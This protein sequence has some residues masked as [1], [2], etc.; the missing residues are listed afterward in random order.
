M[1]SPVLKPSWS[2]APFNAVILIHE[3]KL[4]N[5]QAILPIL[6]AVVQSGRP[7]LIIA[8]DTPV[9]NAGVVM[10]TAPVMSGHRNFMKF[11]QTHGPQTFET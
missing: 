8:E 11:R 9:G 4:S 1:R 2:P 10:P 3:K 7:L 6:E 5:L